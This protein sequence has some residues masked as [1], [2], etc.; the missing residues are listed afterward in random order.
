MTASVA[1]DP[2]A[3]IQDKKGQ[4]EHDLAFLGESAQVKLL[5]TGAISRFSP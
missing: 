4:V 1:R 5:I 2:G 3:A